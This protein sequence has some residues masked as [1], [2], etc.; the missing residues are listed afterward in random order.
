MVECNKQQQ[1]QSLA[2]TNSQYNTHS[3]LLLT[4]VAKL[5]ILYQH[6]KRSTQ[7]MIIMAKFSGCCIWRRLGYLLATFSMG[8]TFP[9]VQY[10]LGCIAAFYYNRLPGLSNHHLLRLYQSI[11]YPS[12]VLQPSTVQLS[13][14][15][16]HFSSSVLPVAA[17]PIFAFSPCPWVVHGLGG[18]VL[19]LS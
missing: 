11:S 1:V 13:Q 17:F 5:C 3:N 19:K 8:Y 6:Y 4:Y 16:R 10:H 14:S 2:I 9:F 18:W 15:P 7:P 12:E